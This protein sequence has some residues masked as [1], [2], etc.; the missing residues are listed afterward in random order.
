MSVIRT[1]KCDGCGAITRAYPDDWFR[2]QVRRM[3][4]NNHDGKLDYTSLSRQSVWL[5][6]CSVECG[7]LAMEPSRCE[8]EALELPA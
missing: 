3:A 8:I 4:G 1:Y 2:I 5:H 7:A 6:V